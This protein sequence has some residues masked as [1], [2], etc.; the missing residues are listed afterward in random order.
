MG[1]TKRFLSCVAAVMLTVL[2]L[3]LLTQLMVKKDSYAKHQEFFDQKAPYDV[4]FV[5][6]S[7]MMNGV[8]PMELW[9]EYGLVSYNLAQAGHPLPANYWV[10]RLA[11]E[12]HE[13]KLVV[14]DCFSHDV[15][16]KT[17]ST[18]GLMHISLDSFP[19]SLTKTQAI[20]DLL[21]DPNS[22]N[23]DS[24]EPREKINLLWNFSV[25]HDRW[26]SL[27]E[28]DFRPQKSYMRGAVIN[29]EIFPGTMEKISASEKQ[30]VKSV[31]LDYLKL[32]I[33]ECQNR[34]IDV[35]LTYLPFPATEV[36][37]K[38]AN[39]LSDIAKQYSVDYINFLNLDVIDY[40]IDMADNNLHL[41]VSGA[42]K[43]TN[44]LGEYI[45]KKYNF[46]DHRQDSKYTNWIEDFDVYT[47]LKNIDISSQQDLYKT[48]LLISNDNLDA[49]ITIQDQE[50][51]EDPQIRTLLKNLG[52]DPACLN[53]ET[54]LL[55]IEDG[56]KRSSAIS[57]FTPG[58]N[59]TD[60]TLGHIS[61]T[62]DT[63]AL[64]KYYI[65]VNGTELTAD[66]SYDVCV[67]ITRGGAFVDYVA[68]NFVLDKEN[69]KIQQIE[70]I[71]P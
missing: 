23:T 19:A 8:F 71:R 6:A 34:E 4:F 32:M 17:S 59:Y 14:I 51:F 22:Y 13:P 1:K 45:A 36:V 47:N 40:S 10:M 29:T 39:A 67:S 30:E 26:A 52:I 15:D 58:T 66:S 49:V 2:V 48:L 44:Y 33:E 27:E 18:F 56:G 64:S 65:C 55:I 9:K 68:Y 57:G 42:R 35:L 54:N 46:A 53:S 5:G 28:N 31:G 70:V 37:Q 41:N 7:H 62:K 61:S 25:F 50:L 20:F 24:G 38:K 21:D 3:S 63:D 16:I 11:F 69:C 12:H 43:V 60:K